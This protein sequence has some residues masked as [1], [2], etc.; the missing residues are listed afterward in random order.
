[1]STTTLRVVV[2]SVGSGDHIL[3]CLP[4]GKYGII[5]LHSQWK[6]LRQLEPPAVTY[7]RN[8]FNNKKFQLAFLH[9]SHGDFDHIKEFKSTWQFLEQKNSLPEYFLTFVGGNILNLLMALK[10]H[11][12]QIRDK[13]GRQFVSRLAKELDYITKVGNNGGQEYKTQHITGITRLPISTTWEGFTKVFA[14]APLAKHT[15]TFN[16]RVVNQKDLQS[17]LPDEED[18]YLGESSKSSVNKNFVSGALLM[19]CCNLN[20]IFGGDVT[21]EMWIDILKEIRTSYPEVN[22]S[23][24]RA[25]FIKGSHHGSR[26]SSSIHIWQKLIADLPEGPDKHVVFSAGKKYKHPAKETWDH[27]ELA[28]EG[29]DSNVIPLSTNMCLFPENDEKR[30]LG[31]RSFITEDLTELLTLRGNGQFIEDKKIAGMDGGFMVEPKKSAGKF[32]H[33][34]AIVYDIDIEST[35]IEVSLWVKMLDEEP[36]TDCFFPPSKSHFRNLQPPQE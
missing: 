27:I 36:D 18:V 19:N 21:D 6:R 32:E 1:M 16:Q 3:L 28:S 31:S 24:W 14:L 26:H 23:A 34:A 30:I 10:N 9:L 11:A 5:D 13:N 20:L 4:N 2:F 7:L 33:L 12:K 8:K 22:E 15:N 29:F 35:E 25:H 17:L